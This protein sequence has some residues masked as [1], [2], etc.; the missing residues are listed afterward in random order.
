MS[1]TLVANSPQRLRQGRQHLSFW[2]VLKS[3]NTK[4]LSL[5]GSWILFGVIFVVGIS[6]SSIVAYST[7]AAYRDGPEADVGA[8]GGQG[9]FAVQTTGD[10]LEQALLAPF[11]N[12]GVVS[13]LIAV[14]CVFL[15]TN[16]YVRN[17]PIVYTLTACPSR[18][19]VFSSKVVIGLF[20]TACVGLLTIIGSIV[21]TRLIFGDNDLADKLV[22][23]DLVPLIG[24]VLCV[25]LLMS[26]V[27]VSVGFMTQSAAISICIAAGLLLVLP[28]VFSSLSVDWADDVAKF[29]PSSL[30]SDLATHEKDAQLDHH[31]QDILCL[32]AWS[33][34]F[35]VPAAWIFKKKDA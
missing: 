33:L 8:S 24:R 29:L 17:R 34:L 6:V 3:E 28:M 12:Q 25:F 2:G 26:I 31:W 20:Y 27:G 19:M 16:E 15:A 23:G 18:G 9:G 1:D 21:A 13:L 22:V 35:L 11:A 5:T 32:G 10:P 30:S 14:L 7:L 4:F